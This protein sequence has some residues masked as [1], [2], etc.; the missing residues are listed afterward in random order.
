MNAVDVD[1]ASCKLSSWSVLQDPESLVQQFNA[2]FAK[3]C[4][5]DNRIHA[6]ELAL[7]LA[8]LLGSTVDSARELLRR[9]AASVQASDCISHGF[10]L[11]QCFD[12]LICLL[13]AN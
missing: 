8:C 13:C 7:A 2:C 11:K 12:V 4:R 9:A 10:P 6:E 3:A 1:S 5:L